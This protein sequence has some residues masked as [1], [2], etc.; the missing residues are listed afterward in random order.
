MY[1]VPEGIEDGRGF[2]QPATTDYDDVDDALLP[3]PPPPPQ[4]DEYQLITIHQKP[5]IDRDG[6]QIDITP[7]PD[8]D[9]IYNN[10][11][12]IYGNE[13]PLHESPLNDYDDPVLLSPPS[14]NPTRGSD[15]D[16]PD[17]MLQKSFSK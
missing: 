12:P 9:P 13:V 11:G 6:D 14:I 15:Y 5:S 1:D 17:A 10:E 16:D 3:P 8:E 4:E 2:V 7:V